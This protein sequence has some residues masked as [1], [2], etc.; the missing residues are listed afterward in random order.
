L[1]GLVS[2]LASDTLGGIPGLHNR[3]TTGCRHF[4]YQGVGLFHHLSGACLK[5]LEHSF[6]LIELALYCSSDLCCRIGHNILDPLF[7]HRFPSPQLRGY[8]RQLLNSRRA[9]TSA[10][11]RLA[12]R[13][14]GRSADN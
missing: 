6:A 9:K 11:N 4:A 1:S 12:T 7:V 5:I 13:A 3:L 14:C 8:H 2:H 10:R